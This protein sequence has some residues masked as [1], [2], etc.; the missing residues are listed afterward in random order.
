[1]LVQEILNHRKDS[2]IGVWEAEIPLSTIGEVAG[3]RTVTATARY[4]FSADGYVT[5]E[6]LPHEEGMD[7]QRDIYQYAP[8]GDSLTFMKNNSV[9]QHYTYR[10][11]GD[12]LALAGRLDLVLQR[13][14]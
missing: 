5:F 11:S 3:S 9:E 12:T 8:S 2:L 7:G 1:M 13:V 14:G 6:I 4:T 10:V